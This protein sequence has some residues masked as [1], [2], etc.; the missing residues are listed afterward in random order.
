MRALPLPLLAALALPAAARAYTIESV[1]TSG[2]HE[3]V[4]R[5]ALAQAGW[6]AGA[7]LKKP[8]GAN[9]GLADAVAFTVAR[10]SDEWLITV[11]LGARDNDLHGAGA[12]DFTELS[13]LHNAAEGQ[14]EHCLRAPSED[15]SEGDRSA[16]ERCRGYIRSQL[17]A[18][19][20]AGAAPDLGA[21]EA[22]PVALRDRITTLSLPRYPLLLG[23][24]LHALQDSF[25]HTYRD[26][27]F[28]A[29]TTVFNYSDP[30]MAASYDPARD[31]VQH[32]SDFDGCEG[33][34]ERQ[35]QRVA[36][37]TQASA[38]LLSALAAEGTNA[39]RLSRADAVLDRWL[40]AVPGCFE[41]ERYCGSDEPYPKSCAAA[42]GAPLL[43]LG[44][45]ALRRRRAR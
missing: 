14:E 26:G 19:L 39:E 42:P 10:D 9:A 15:G 3:R 30:A 1:A 16:V 36:A 34:S 27:D 43:A 4:T 2:C 28:R 12:S 37:S 24:A 32:R 13:A 29:I 31:G 22:L 8:E 25:T 20:G 17:E 41:T 23:R 5:A 40:K 38:E 11:L 7:E 44:L 45:L 33:G 18:A 6:P 35:V 21:T